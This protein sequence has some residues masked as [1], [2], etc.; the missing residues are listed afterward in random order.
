MAVNGRIEYSLFDERR[1][2]PPIHRSVKLKQLQLEQDSG[3]SL[4]DDI[5]QETLVDLSRAG[6]SK[7]KFYTRLS[8]CI[9]R[10]GF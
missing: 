8:Y 10:Y 7:T 9:L 5:N 4:H 2:E 1:K 3:K 6:R